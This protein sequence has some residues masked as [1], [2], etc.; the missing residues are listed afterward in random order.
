M[1]DTGAG[2]NLIKRERQASSGVVTASTIGVDHFNQLIPDLLDQHMH[3]STHTHS[4]ILCGGDR[5]LEIVQHLRLSRRFLT[6]SHAHTPPV[7]GLYV[8]SQAVKTDRPSQS[9]RLERAGEREREGFGSLSLRCSTLL[10]GQASHTHAPLRSFPH[11]LSLFSSQLSSRFCS[12]GFPGALQTAVERDG[13]TFP[14]EIP[15]PYTSTA[16]SAPSLPSFL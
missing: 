4:L 11:A 14:G 13:K 12:Q 6:S 3:G 7:R 2:R 8:R 5:P 1:A 9:S 15:Q 16:R 10:N